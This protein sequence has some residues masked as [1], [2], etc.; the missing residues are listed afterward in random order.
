MEMLTRFRRI[1]ARGS[2]P[3]RGIEAR[4]GEARGVTAGVTAI[5]QTLLLDIA[6]TCPEKNSEPA[7]RKRARCNFFFPLPGGLSRIRE[8]NSRCNAGAHALSLVPRDYYV[9]GRVLVL[10]DNINACGNKYSYN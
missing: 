8:I 6:R 9:S 3:S 4:K 7:E 5:K 1:A 10:R 2:L